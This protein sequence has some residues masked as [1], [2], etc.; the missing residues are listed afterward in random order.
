MI[1]IPI[2]WLVVTGIFAI[3]SIVAVLAQ[4]ALIVVLI[5]LV[6][7]LQP[8]IGMIAGKVEAIADRVEGIAQRVE[9]VSQSAKGIAE[10]ARGTVQTLTGRAETVASKFQHVAT[11]S[12]D[13]VEN[14][15]RSFAPFFVYARL[16]FE[17]LSKFADF[18][19]ERQRDRRDYRDGTMGELR[20]PVNDN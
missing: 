20:A 17:L 15:M 7:D 13:S 16:A 14:R 2:W 6:K 4:A 5:K 19:S 12:S 1:E 9:S 11:L 8:R 3:V 10:S 18:K